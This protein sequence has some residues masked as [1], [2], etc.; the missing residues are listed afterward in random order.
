MEEKNNCCLNDKLSQEQ[1]I[2]LLKMVLDD[3][4]F[5]AIAHNTSKINEAFEL[6]MTNILIQTQGLE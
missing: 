6:N 1:K 5:R 4:S 2:T 3:E